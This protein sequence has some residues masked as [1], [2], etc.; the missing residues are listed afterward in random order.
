[1]AGPNTCGQPLSSERNATKLPRV[2]TQRSDSFGT[3]SFPGENVLGEVS[4]PGRRNAA[5]LQHA[6]AAIGVAPK[7]PL[8]LWIKSDSETGCRTAEWRAPRETRRAMAASL[9]VERFEPR[10][11]IGDIL[12]R[13]AFNRSS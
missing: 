13:K 4:S 2:R 6:Q 11:Q 10:E 9:G 12:F 3:R 8:D 7:N 5:E 1:M